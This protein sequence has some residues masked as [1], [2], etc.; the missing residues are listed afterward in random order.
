MHLAL[1]HAILR[2]CHAIFRLQRFEERLRYDAKESP[3]RS[4]VQSNPR[5]TI[6]TNDEGD[7]NSNKPITTIAAGAFL[8]ENA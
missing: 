5:E 8:R 7:R 1:M 4:Q 3:S 6:S 2:L